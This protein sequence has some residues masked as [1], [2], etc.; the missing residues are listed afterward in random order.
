MEKKV[1][2][3]FLFYF[4]ICLQLMQNSCKD[5]SFGSTDSVPPPE[6]DSI[7]YWLSEENSSSAE[8]YAQNISKANELALK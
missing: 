1:N 6:N 4:I 2:Y 7:T 3:K 5:T 8:E